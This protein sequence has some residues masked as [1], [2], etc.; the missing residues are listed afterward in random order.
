ML[1]LCTTVQN[2]SKQRGVKN[3]DPIPL[4]EHQWTGLILS[5]LPWQIQARG[6]AGSSQQW[7]WEGTQAGKYAKY[8]SLPIPK[9]AEREDLESLLIS[10][11]Y[12]MVVAPYL[13]SGYTLPMSS[14]APFS[15]PFGSCC[16]K[17]HCGDTVE[18]GFQCSWLTTPTYFLP[19]QNVLIMK[20]FHNDLLVI[21]PFS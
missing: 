19:A 4:N 10:D 18:A 20:T 8:N 15:P 2:K 21:I 9:A 5:S 11:G 1:Q 13:P 3:Q 7:L 14:L 17:E 6:K 16:R 12:V